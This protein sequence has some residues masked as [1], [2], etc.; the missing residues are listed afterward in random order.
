MWSDTDHACVNT[1]FL[2]HVHTGQQ[3]TGVIHEWDTQS[4]EIRRTRSPGAS[5][6]R[7]SNTLPRASVPELTAPPIRRR[8]GGGYL[9]GGTTGV[10]GVADVAQGLADPTWDAP[11]TGNASVYNSSPTSWRTADYEKQPQ[12]DSEWAQWPTAETPGQLS[13]CWLVGCFVLA[14]VDLWPSI[15]EA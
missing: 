1:F 7:T 3:P 11:G 2:P 8:S 15:F 6:P 4:E 10:Q 5:P 9:S 12:L 13:S 14:D